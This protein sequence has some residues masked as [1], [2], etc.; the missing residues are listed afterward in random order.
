ML[1]RSRS[2]EARVSL[3]GGCAI[4]VRPVDQHIKALEAMGASIAIEHGYIHATAT[5]LK[6]ARIL[7]DMVGQG[8]EHLLGQHGGGAVQLGHREVDPARLPDHPD[9][10]DLWDAIAR[11]E[12]PLLL[13]RGMRGLERKLKAGLGKQVG[14]TPDQELHRPETTG[15]GAGGALG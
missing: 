15:V 5:R 4:G 10:R 2:G 6:G 9:Y 3:P 7:F 12:V 11:I 14:R 1:F 8:G 13:T